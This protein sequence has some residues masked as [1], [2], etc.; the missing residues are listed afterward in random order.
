M[1]YRPPTPP[2]FFPVDR[3]DVST[4]PNNEANLCPS[5]SSHGSID[6][7]IDPMPIFPAFV[8]NDYSASTLRLDVADHQPH[9][10]V[11]NIN[12]SSRKMN[13]IDNDDDGRA[14]FSAAATGISGSNAAKG[15]KR[16]D[17]FEPLPFRASEDFAGIDD[18]ASKAYMNASHF[19]RASGQDCVGGY[20]GEQI[21]RQVYP[22]YGNNTVDPTSPARVQPPII[23]HAQTNDE[24]HADNVTNKGH[25]KVPSF[26]TPLRGYDDVMIEDSKAAPNHHAYGGYQHHYHGHHGYYPPYH[27]WQQQYGGSGHVQ[28]HEHG[29][30]RQQ[31]H[32]QGVIPH[33]PSA[34]PI[35]H[36]LANDMGAATS[37]PTIKRRYFQDNRHDGAFGTPVPAYHRPPLPSHGPIHHYNEQDSDS[38]KIEAA[39]RRGPSIIFDNDEDWHQQSPTVLYRSWSSGGSSTTTA[40]ANVRDGLVMAPK[41]QSKKKAVAKKKRKSKST[42]TTLP[43]DDMSPLPVLFTTNDDNIEMNDE[44]GS[45]SDDD[46][47]VS[48]LD[49]DLPLEPLVKFQKMMKSSEATQKALEK[50]DKKMGLKRSHSKTMWVSPLRAAELPWMYSSKKN[51]SHLCYVLQSSFAN[52][53]RTGQ[54][55]SFR[56][57][58]L[59]FSAQ[60]CVW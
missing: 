58:S 57:P 6:M 9:P 18:M 13:D 47:M 44:D 17:T 53:T 35:F 27:L 22:V 12:G 21:H 45:E 3:R 41:K 28:Y 16:G 38:H 54:G 51:R 30:Y 43:N 34:P 8:G 1:S 52:R 29:P 39:H 55:R 32:Q 36:P 49:M 10:L 4:M 26:V 25:R 59:V 23:S 15:H 46:V 20:A 48:N 37:K 31:R 19:G 33:R 14:A 11:T 2:A 42:L 24:Q 56:T 50:W 5:R 7:S 60:N 40:T